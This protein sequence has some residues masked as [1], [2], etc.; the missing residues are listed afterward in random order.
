MAEGF[1]RNAGFAVADPALDPALRKQ[2]A[3]ALRLESRRQRVAAEDAKQQVAP[4]RGGGKIG[5]RSEKVKALHAYIRELL[6]AWPTWKPARL[7]EK[8]V[9]KA[10]IGNLSKPRFDE[11]V[12]TVLEEDASRK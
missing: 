12:R 4:Y 2:L 3:A 7:Y 11:H 10:T 9:D 5:R 6:K 8:V 1:L